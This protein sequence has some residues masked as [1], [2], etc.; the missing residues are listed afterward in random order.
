[1]IL[2]GATLMKST[3][4]SAV[5]MGRLRY[6]PNPNCDQKGVSLKWTHVI[7][8]MVFDPWVNVRQTNDYILT[9]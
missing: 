5:Q 6:S 4:D 7:G 3:V 2:I 8:S 9:N 1:M